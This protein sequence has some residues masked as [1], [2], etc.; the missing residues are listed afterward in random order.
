M[1]LLTA[2]IGA[3]RRC[4]SPCWAA[5]STGSRGRARAALGEE[6]GTLLLL[7]GVLAASIALVALQSTIKQQTL[8]GNFPM[9]L[10]WNFHRLML[11]RAWAS[12]RTSSPAASRPR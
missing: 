12:T 2:V 10:R 8:V 5:S 4:C 7:A 11:A 6:R 9:R 3:S 1:T